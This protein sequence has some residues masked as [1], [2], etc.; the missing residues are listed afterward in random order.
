MAEQRYTTS[1]FAYHLPDELIA[2][3]P[4]PARGASRLLV[5]DRSASTRQSALLDRQF[6]DFPTL[7]AP[8]DLLVLNST[9][10]RHAR[11]LATRPLGGPAEVL[12]LHPIADGTWLALGKPGRA[13]LPGKRLDLGDGIAVETVAVRPDGLREI[14]FVGG[15]AETAINRFG[16]IPL[17]PYVTREPTPADHDRY[18]TVY[19]DRVGSVAAPTAGLHLTHAMLD[20]VR[21]DGVAIATL[22]LEVGPG[23]FKPVE[24]QHPADHPMHAERLEIPEATA[25]AIREARQRGGAVWAVGTTVVRALESAATADGTVL[26]GQRETR[27]LITPGYRFKVV[28]RLLTNFHLPQSTLLMLVAAFGGYDRVMAAYR[29]AIAARYRFYSYGDA[30]CIL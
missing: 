15:D 16:R 10:V 14:R 21:A 5:V 25:A 17:P 9:R 6:A 26:A 7:L 18:Q 2:Q 30:M 1:D 22:D 24:V 19:A 28:D 12:L 13:M 4:S 11:L 27:L 3:V 29:H 20:Q 23:T 8:G